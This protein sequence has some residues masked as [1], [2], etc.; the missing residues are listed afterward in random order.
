M[1]LFWAHGEVCP[2]D[3]LVGLSRE[4]RSTHVV[5]YSTGSN[6]GALGSGS[7]KS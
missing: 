7:I 4:Q 5:R 1:V 2:L 6:A 3:L